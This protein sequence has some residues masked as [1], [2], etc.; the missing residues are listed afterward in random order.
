MTWLL[1]FILLVV[2]DFLFFRFY[3]GVN[4]GIYCFILVLFTAPFFKHQISNWVL[5]LVMVSSL[6]FDC[7]VLNCT[8]FI[9]VFLFLLYSRENRNNSYTF[10]SIMKT[11]LL[12]I[13][14]S[15]ITILVDF[16]STI[17]LLVYSGTNSQIFFRKSFYWAISI[18]ISCIFLFLFYLANPFLQIKID[19]LFEYLMEAFTNIFEWSLFFRI[20]LW[21]FL[22]F[23]AWAI[24]RTVKKAEAITHKKENH[25]WLPLELVICSLI[26][27][28]VVFGVQSITDLYFLLGDG[29]LPE[30][31]TFADYAHRGAYPLIVVTLLS[32]ALICLIFKDGYQSQKSKVARYL[33]YAWLF[34]NILLALFT[35]Q[36]LSLYVSYFHLTRWRY[37]T[38]IWLFLIIFGFILTFYRIRFQKTNQW[39]LRQNMYLTFWVLLICCFVKSDFL[40]SYYNVTHCKEYTGKGNKLDIAYLESLG[41]SALPAIQFARIN[42]SESMNELLLAK[43]R[44]ELIYLIKEKNWREKSIFESMVIYWFSE[45]K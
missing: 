11:V 1:V 36:R 3:I 33:V 30:G 28:N 45:K 19:F 22:F 29:L 24:L 26:C 38:F 41:I 14:N 21:C 5:L 7:T 31:L 18:G 25:E 6:I 12:F 32:G 8:F 40:I 35:I 10:F 15:I 2:G 34:Q 20:I 42:K 4:L 23:S 27:F 16:M 13:M 17:E 43:D 44:I 39:F 37:A 9:F